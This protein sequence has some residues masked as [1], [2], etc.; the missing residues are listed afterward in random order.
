MAGAYIGVSNI[1]QKVKNGYVGVANV[2]RKIKYG[3]IGVSNV[4]RKFYS[5]ET[6]FYNEGDTCSA[7][8]GGWVSKY[9]NDAEDPATT[10]Q[11]GQPNLELKSDH[12]LMQ[13]PDQTAS[14]SSTSN[15]TG[16]FT[17]KNKIDWSKYTTLYIKHTLTF[18]S[19]LGTTAVA[20]YGVNKDKYGRADSGDSHWIAWGYRNSS[21]GSV[22]E[23]TVAI[24]VSWV[25]E[26]H[27]IGIYIQRLLTEVSK[28]GD[29]SMT[30]KVYRIWAE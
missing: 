20:R 17:T 22:A 26:S 28:T 16:I 15:M 21:G 12:I 4:A 6:N 24:D 18:G 27:Y 25:T 11:T 2:A 7:E 13:I 9:G 5:S 19:A 23:Y 3:Y 29:D 30:L 10:G 14:N 8:T 1:A